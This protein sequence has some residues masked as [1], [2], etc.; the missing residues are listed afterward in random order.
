MNKNIEKGGIA[1]VAIAPEQNIIVF[2]LREDLKYFFIEIFMIL[3][4]QK[5]AFY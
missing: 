3:I 2:N 5:M 4:F 1:K